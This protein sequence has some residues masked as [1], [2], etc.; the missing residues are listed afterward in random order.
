MGRHVVEVA[1]ARGHEVVVLARS[2]GVDLTTGAGLD[3]S[4]IDAVI[5]VTSIQRV[6]AGTALLN[7]KP[8]PSEQPCS[9]RKTAP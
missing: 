7:R 5:D 9:T 2:E 4:G 3:L 6:E 8:C 1:R